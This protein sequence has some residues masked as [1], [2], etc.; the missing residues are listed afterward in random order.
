MLSELQNN[1][2]IITSDVI[3]KRIQYCLSLR[4]AFEILN[5]LF[6]NREQTWEQLKETIINLGFLKNDS[7][8]ILIDRLMYVKEVL[9]KMKVKFPQQE[10]K[11][12]D[13]YEV[14][15]S[16]H[17]IKDSK[18]VLQ[19]LLQLV[20]YGRHQETRIHLLN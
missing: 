18:K 19:F 17:E 12:K 9:L 4:D 13:I 15:N 3:H 6:T 5:Q 16:V 7:H 1:R 2:Q 20:V 14:L 10:L 11:L 8:Q